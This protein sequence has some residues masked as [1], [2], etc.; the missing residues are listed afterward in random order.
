MANVKNTAVQAFLDENA[1][2]IDE[3]LATFAGSAEL[4]SAS[5]PRF[6][7]QYE[8]K[9]VAAHDGA[10]VAVGDTLDSVMAMIAKAGLSPS[11]TMIRHIDRDE[12][13][14]IM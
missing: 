2:R 13:T 11:E 6:I 7:D 4:F 8:N 10:V 14:L 1:Q 9:W 5:K 3:H 12:K